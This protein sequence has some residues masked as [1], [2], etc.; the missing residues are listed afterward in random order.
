MRDF[1]HRSLTRNFVKRNRV[2][3]PEYHVKNRF[4]F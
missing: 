3:L 4:F 2:A 1:S